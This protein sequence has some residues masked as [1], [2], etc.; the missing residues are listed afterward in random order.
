MRTKTNR[1]KLQLK[2]RIK[3]YRQ[4]TDKHT[5]R[6]SRSY[7]ADFFILYIAPFIPLFNLTFNKSQQH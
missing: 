7:P 2:T 4:S 5:D 1:L 6:H 3:A